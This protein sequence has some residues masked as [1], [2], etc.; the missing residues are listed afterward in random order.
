MPNY[1]GP[2]RFGREAGNLEQVMDAAERLAA[3]PPRRGKAAGRRGFMLSAARSVI[4]NAIVAARVEQR[5]LEPAAARRRRQPRWTWQRVCGRGPDD[6]T[7][8]RCAALEI[9]PTAPLPG[10][11]ESLAQGE[12]RQLEEATAAYSP[13]ALAVIAP[14]A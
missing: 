7:E 6:G 14:S 4:F 12:V 2:Q 13:E 10:A 9:H 11:G 5:D 3:G 8:S 1:F